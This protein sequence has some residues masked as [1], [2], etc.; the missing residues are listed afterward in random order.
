MMKKKLLLLAFFMAML[1]Q[2]SAQLFQQNFQMPNHYFHSVFTAQL[3]DSSQDLLVVG[4]LFDSTLQNPEIQV[5]KI[6]DITGNVVGQKIYYD[7]SSAIQNPRVFDFVTYEENGNQMIAMTGSVTVS[8]MNYAFIAKLSQ[9]GTYMGGAYY[10]SLVPGAMHSQ[11]LHIIRSQQGFVVGG[12]TN[13][14]YNS[15]TNDLTSGFV[16]KTD[17]NLTPIWSRELWTN[18]Q[19][20]TRDYDMVNHILETDDGYFVT[21]SVTSVPFST[22][23][24]VLCLKFDFSGNIVWTQSYVYG[25]SNDVGVDAY[26]NTSSDEIFL[27]CNYSNSHYFGITVLNDNT[28]VIDLARSW[29]AYDWNNLN[30]YAFSVLESASDSS[31]L[32]VSG[33][34]RDG[35]VLNQDS[36][37]VFGQTIP[38]VYEFQKSSGDQVGDVYYYDVV[39]QPPVFNDY[40]D[41]W[42]AQMPLIYYPDMSIKLQNDDQYFHVAYRSD[43]ANGLTNIEM[44]KADQNHV[45]PC[46][47]SRINLDHDAIVVTSTATL[48]NNQSPVA[49]NFDLSADDRNYVL[50]VSCIYEGPPCSCETLAADVA[51]G[52]TYVITG[53]SVD[54]TPVSLD[55]ECD[56]VEWNFGDGN[57]AYSAGNQTVTHI[58]PFSKEYDVCMKVTRITGTGEVCKDSICTTVDLTTVGMLYDKEP[59][60]HIWPNPVKKFLYVSSKNEQWKGAG[61]KVINLHGETVLYGKLKESQITGINVEQLPAGIYLLQFKSARE[62]LRYKLLK[63][64]NY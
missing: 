26:F 54:F 42:S 22:Q 61:Y 58:F 12:F 49:T 37:L 14:D 39:C 29:R 32:V 38:F 45:N 41:F 43:S 28:G 7:P 63:Q 16:L 56:S 10:D 8:G 31:N 33:Y 52:F 53:Y 48:V 15:G 46:Y 23:Q 9:N 20:A 11:G 34:I 13:M 17:N 40:F 30:R 55:V 6:D 21:G 64:K 35:Q 25:N 3:N 62:T 47:R 44:I 50:N 57:Y 19:N 18:L 2:L 60:L 27:L 24:A 1:N 5:I 4:S 36:V 51:A 59:S